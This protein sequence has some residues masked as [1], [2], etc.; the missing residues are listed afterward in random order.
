[1]TGCHCH[2]EA[3]RDG[4]GQRGRYL[5]ALDPSYAPVDGRTI[6]DLLVF[7]KRYAAQI[8]FYDVPG[9]EVPDGPP[10]RVSWREFF[11]RDMAVI[12]ASI[13]RVDTEQ[14]EKD[15]GELRA[16]FEAK[17]GR[18]TF[19]ALFD[20]ILGMAKRIGRWHSIAIA[21][22]PLRADLD[23]AVASTLRAG[24]D[25][26]RAFE[27]GFAFV[28]PTHRLDLDY[29]TLDASLWGL[30][31]PV[32]ADA[33]VYEGADLGA[34][35]RNAA[36][37]V[38]DV[39]HAFYGF[40]RQLVTVNAV[41]YMRFALQAYPAHQPHMALFIAFL[42]LFRLAQDQMNGLTARMLD[43]YYEDVLHLAPKPPIPDRVHVVFELA[44]DVVDY[45]I[46]AGTPLKAGKDAA[47]KTLTY[48][49]TGDLVVNQARVG[50]LKTL[51]VAKSASV[52]P[53]KV[54]LGGIFARPVANS[55]DGFGA[56]LPQTGGKWPTFGKGAVA[57]KP[58]T[59]CD[60]IAAMGEQDDPRNDRARIGFALASP[61]LLL[62]GG[63]R[64]L[65]W[66]LPAQA[67]ALISAVELTGEKGWLTVA[68]LDRD[69]DRDLI[70]LLT[71]AEQ[72][73]FDPAIDVGSAR[74][75]THE[76][77]LY[78]YLPVAEV[79]VVAFDAGL[80]TGPV[81]P[82]PHP[83]IR[84]L[85]D[86]GTEF[87]SATWITLQLG[88]QALA[89]RVGSID[90][91]RQ[92]F[93]GL[94]SLVVENA[95]ERVDATKPFDPFTLLP[96]S[97]MPLYI[98][99]GEI[100]N[101]PFVA[102]DKLV[103]LAVNIRK[104]TDVEQ[105]AAAQL[106]LYNAYV[107]RGR[108]WVELAR[109]AGDDVELFRRVDLARNILFTKVGDATERL[110]LA[111]LPLIAEDDLTLE[112]S[113]GFLR[114]DLVA[115]GDFAGLPP[116]VLAAAL[117]VKELSISYYSVLPELDADVEQFF[118]V[119]PFGVAEVFLGGP[120]A[121]L[122]ASRG[123]LVVDANQRLLPQFTFLAPDAAYRTAFRDTQRPRVA[124][125]GAATPSP[126]ETLIDTLVQQANASSPGSGGANQ[127]DGEQQEEGMLLVGLE[128]LRPLDTL[129]LLFEF[130]Q[131][132][133]AD[134]DG[135]PPPIHWSY[136]TNNEWRPLNGESLVSDGTYGFQ[137]TGIVRIDVPRD[138][139]DDNTIAT[140]GL[141]WFAASV[142][143][144]SE[145]IPML[146]DVVAQAAV[147]QLV[148]NDNDA[149]HFDAALPA[150]TIGK[151]A[152]AVAEIA[153]VTQPFA[154]F[155]GKHREVGR[156][157]YTRV[158]ERLRHKARAITA[159]DYEHLVLDRFPSIY[160]V[161]CIQHTDPNCLCRTV[162]ADGN[163]CCG[164]QIAPGHVLIVPIAN[165]KHRN[166]VN[167]LQPKTSRGTL[168]EI[169]AYLAQRTSPFVRVHARNPVYEPI[170]VFFQVQFMP[171]A[172]KGYYLKKLND[173]IVRF[174]T[175]WAF[176]EDAEVSFD[177]KI[178]ASAII[179]FIE[180]RPYV[181][182][183]TDFLMFVCRER[184]CPDDAADSGTRV[185]ASDALAKMNGCCDAETLFAGSGGHFVCDVIAT[186]S[187]P[188]SILV[189]APR[190]FIIP[191]ATQTKPTPCEVRRAAKQAPPAPP[192]P[193]P[194]LPAPSEP[195]P[196]PGPAA[197]RATRRAD[198]AGPPRRRR[199]SRNPT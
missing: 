96:Q 83:V 30:D 139:T 20:P 60:R 186:P 80:H 174:L 81:Y 170:V 82:T 114:I 187:T 182:F 67:I 56:P 198:G 58:Q 13:A 64:L 29:S 115:R 55:V 73:V 50:A 98:G 8:R 15:Y 101:K 126:C 33:S 181:D 189:S 177:Q 86:P 123:D 26:V 105:R 74:Y 28:D 108:Q 61:Q 183:I 143:D 17:P 127:Y 32:P 142:T 159:R 133:A 154:S 70:K 141:M 4:S 97:G 178:Y 25:R 197:K 179:K 43:F 144:H 156:E 116:N 24:V 62:Q 14:L 146:V 172:S 36:L 91:R 39:F 79:A 63:N 99:S 102:D 110:P 89:V 151:L 52:D 191:Y 150:G 76:D 45:D 38:D 165:L 92:H 51:H 145:R 57:A 176:D 140:T 192:A 12:A 136:L 199:G 184:C 120:D 190:H 88:K 173:E 59:L 6:E 169:Q 3:P 18:A 175:P 19:A 9:G 71:R 162:K 130:A 47:G 196:V 65:R 54:T 49:T 41:G 95:S 157:F 46:A 180:D 153:K 5:A 125:A 149:S 152:V 168:L 37:Y 106:E 72:G 138:I 90:E 77:S 40:V 84:V 134:E 163:V 78:V 109:N 131:G 193:E 118:H 2:C 7:A 21:G 124:M 68:R 27:E 167:P 171:G 113:K 35:L 188:R 75:F 85:V 155:D 22:N 100:F 121:A 94:T 87:P 48:A 44:K 93:D 166:A 11:R 128:G 148:D 129:S 185:S 160:K 66:R 53:A 112:S 34:K 107:L 111:R 122:D 103:A 194:A 42:E 16:A 117:K 158:S 161:K 1:M 23:L 135:D 119:Y 147:A 104:V 164:P 69:A 137:T 132:S 31:K 10:E 195:R